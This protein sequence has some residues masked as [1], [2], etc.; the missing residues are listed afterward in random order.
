MKG[1]SDMFFKDICNF[2][3]RGAVI[4]IPKLHM[5]SGEEA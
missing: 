1:H 3:M 4:K 2:N 5:I